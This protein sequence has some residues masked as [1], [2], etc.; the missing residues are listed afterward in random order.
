MRRLVVIVDDNE[1]AA[2]SLALA[3]EKIP[4]VEAVVM[5]HGPAALRLFQT[6]D[7]PI[8]AVITDFNLPYLDGF[9]LIREIRKIPAYRTIPAL[10]VTADRNTSEK[11]GGTVEGPNAILYKPFSSREVCR[12][13][14]KLLQ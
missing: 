2:V 3:V 4:G 8:H 10:M 6:S 14:E 13:M 12:V 1:S 5:Q 11:N 9:E 7:T